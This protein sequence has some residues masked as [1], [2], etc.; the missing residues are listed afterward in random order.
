MAWSLWD[1]SQTHNFSFDFFQYFIQL[2]P[3][4]EYS[5]IH[6]YAMGTPN[7]KTLNQSNFGLEI[8][9]CLE[10]FA[11]KHQRSIKAISLLST[12][13]HSLWKV[14]VN[15]YFDQT[16]ASQEVCPKKKSFPS[17]LSPTSKHHSKHTRELDETNKEAKPRIMEKLFKHF[18]EILSLYVY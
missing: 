11:K 1:L 17:F 13:S 4:E 14:K 2:I 10:T 18:L 15:S 3:R 12:P 8:Q 9:V 5:S 7:L 16:I 6:H